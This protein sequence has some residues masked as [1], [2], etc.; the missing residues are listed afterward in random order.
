MSNWIFSNYFSQTNDILVF[1]IADPLVGRRINVRFPILI[2]ERK[3]SSLNILINYDRIK[4]MEDFKG[5]FELKMNK[6]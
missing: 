2:S 6:L 5:H 3:K 1:N 4:P